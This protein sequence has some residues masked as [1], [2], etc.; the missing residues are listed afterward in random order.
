M[1]M[2][3]YKAEDFSVQMLAVCKVYYGVVQ[4]IAA[5]ANSEGGCFVIGKGNETLAFYAPAVRSH[6]A[7]DCVGRIIV[8]TRFVTLPHLEIEARWHLGC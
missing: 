7:R 2:R 8:L 5:A 3:M 6:F 1:S 4:S